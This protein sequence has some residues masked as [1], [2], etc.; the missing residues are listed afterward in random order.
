MPDT[1]EAG[2][3]GGFSKR[4]PACRVQGC[5]FPVGAD[6]ENSAVA[7]QFTDASQRAEVRRSAELCLV[8][9][10]NGQQQFVIVAAMKRRL[11]CIEPARQEL[12]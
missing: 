9:R 5:S 1:R 11:E 3:T 6:K 4:I 12:P 8:F 2:S 7:S 10:W